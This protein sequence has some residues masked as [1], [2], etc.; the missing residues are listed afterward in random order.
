MGF[1]GDSLPCCS[2]PN[3]WMHGHVRHD[4]CRILH[5]RSTSSISTFVS[6]P[7]L[8]WVSSLT[9]ST[10]GHSPVCLGPSFPILSLITN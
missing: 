10:N 6:S 3:Q 9:A 8:T 7:T 1:I 4:P 5:P 2:C